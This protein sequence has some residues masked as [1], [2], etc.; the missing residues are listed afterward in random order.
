MSKIYPI[1]KKH[2]DKYDFLHLLKNGAPS[3]EYDHESKKISDS[4]INES[5]IEEIAS[6]IASVMSTD[7]GYDYIKPENFIDIAKKIKSDL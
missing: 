5:S 6:V 1:V 3:D 2:I 7:F 4:I